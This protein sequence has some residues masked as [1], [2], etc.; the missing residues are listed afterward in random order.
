[1]GANRINV[2]MTLS[3]VNREL[4]INALIKNPL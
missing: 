4:S 2:M 1:M 3:L